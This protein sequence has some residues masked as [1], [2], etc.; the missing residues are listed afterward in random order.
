MP[1][2]ARRQETAAE[3][4]DRNWNELLQEFRVTQTG[5][6]ILFGFLLILPFQSSF[7][8]VDGPQRLLYLLILACVTIST[9]CILAPVM[10]HRL[11]F[12]RQ[13]KAR[14][15]DLGSTLIKI[16]LAFLGAALVGAVGLTVSV[17]STHSTAWIAASATLVLM[18]VL[19]FV[20]P[21]T[22]GSDKDGG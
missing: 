5:V 13:R 19:W 17:V 14:L 22:M 1:P 8:D 7:T 15:V 18:V 20:V 10:A 9:V 3:R 12:R 21:L 2:E 6:Q 4:L 11:L 16:S